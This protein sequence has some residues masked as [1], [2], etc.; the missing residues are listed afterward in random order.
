MGVCKWACSP[1]FV[2]GCSH[3]SF[4]AIAK[5]IYNLNS[6]SAHVMLYIV[7]MHLTEIVAILLVLSEVPFPSE[8]QNFKTHSLHSTCPVKDCTW[9]TY[10]NHTHTCECGSINDHIVSCK[11]CISDN[12]GCPFE[13]RVLNGFWNK[14]RTETI[15]DACLFNRNKWYEVYSVIP[16][17]LSQ[18]EQT[19]CQ[20]WPVVW[21]M[22]GGILSSCLLLLPTVC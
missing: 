20:D 22:C 9:T 11:S 16:S 15:V 12:D 13:V 1:G 19:V 7:M 3:K 4:I 6:V 14:N 5:L 2:P 10:N 18:L 21:T 17:N 8:G